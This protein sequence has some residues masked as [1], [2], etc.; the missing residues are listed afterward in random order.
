MFRTSKWALPILTSLLTS[1]CGG[2]GGVAST[3]TP[4]GSQTPTPSPTATPSPTPTP[5]RTPAP[6]PTAGT[7]GANSSLMTPLQ[8]E[9]FTA[10]GA[11]AS[12]QFYADKRPVENGNASWGTLSIAYNAGTQSYT[13][14]TAGRTATFAPA[15]L[16][17]SGSTDFI[18]FQK[19]GATSEALTLTKPGTSGALT[20]RYVGGGAWERATLNNGQLDFSYDPFTY[21]VETPDASLVRSGSGL[22]AVSLV[23]ARAMDEPFAMA[24]SG[25]LQVDF[26]SGALISSGT[27]TTIDVDTGLIKGI[28]VYY[29]EATLAS[30]INS[31]SGDF[32]MY[33][34]KR[35]TGGWEGRF[36]GPDAEEVGAAW[37]LKSAD[38][39]AAAGYLIG[40]EDASAVSYNLSLS[41]LTLSESFDH[42]FSEL[43]FTDTG[44]GNAGGNGA[45]LRSDGT[46]AYDATDG[47]F[48]YAD[49]A[50]GISTRFSSASRVTAETTS[51]LSVYRITGSDG[52]TYKLTLNK[53]G[54]GN[55][56]IALSYAS[57]G[58]W[59]KLQGPSSDRLDRWFAWGIRTNG[60][61]IPT[62]TGTY[63]GLIRGT[64]ALM[65]GG[66]TYALSGTSSFSMNFGAQTFT[67]SLNPIGTS[68]VNGSQRDF[69]TFNFASGTIDIDAG[70]NA[71]IVNGS[72]AYLGFFEGALYGPKA[73]EVAGSFGMQTQNTD[74]G[75]TPSSTAAYLTGVIVGT[76]TGN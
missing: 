44:S 17:V 61:Q 10:Q 22:Y 52:L 3:P 38:G 2:G 40:R 48:T 37:H 12:G 49:S 4:G 45:I 42:R 54:A 8:T 68:L 56:A 41:A 67:G 1:A 26:L 66:A 60:F 36:Y 76:R 47:S 69:G 63:S 7:I 31:F 39:E 53:A 6:A 19:I 16:V 50:R 5:G 58:R 55:P 25:S 9:S 13:I 18:S 43:S 46:F 71:N 73:T 75:T 15:D 70:L 20:Y 27:L 11:N 28:G 74:G 57:F 29:G 62:G 65:N 72:N 24:G 64:G 34:G 21:G 23:G 51:A 32:F 59:E 30:T 33:D 35:F 14:S